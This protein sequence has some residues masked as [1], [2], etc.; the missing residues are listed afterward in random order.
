M[1][2]RFVLLCFDEMLGHKIKESVF[3]EVM[4]KKN[5]I[6]VTWARILKENSYQLALTELIHESDQRKTILGIPFDETNTINMLS[7][8]NKF[9]KAMSEHRED[10][11]ASIFQRVAPELAAIYRVPVPDAPV[12]EPAGATNLTKILQRLYIRDPERVPGSSTPAS[13]LVPLDQYLGSTNISLQTLLNVMTWVSRNCDVLDEREKRD[14]D[15]II[16][17]IQF[18]LLLNSTGALNLV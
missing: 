15:S 12:P 16:S 9:I 10:S 1:S 3:N 4:S 18:F 11:L 6:L 5:D 8:V 2:L 7:R 17:V 14:T 13:A